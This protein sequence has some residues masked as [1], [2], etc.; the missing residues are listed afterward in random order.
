M[1]PPASAVQP[2]RR[3]LLR[4]VKQEH[5]LP[6]P[7]L[8]LHAGRRPRPAQPL[9]DEHELVAIVAAARR[10]DADGWKRLVGRFDGGLRVIARSY[11]LAPADVDDVVQATWLE[12]VTAIGRLREPA[13][14]GGW[15][16]TVTRR[17]ALRTRQLPMRELLTDDPCR[18]D[19]D[20]SAG[21]E[22][23][24]LEAERQA[25]LAGAIAALPDRHGRLMTVLLT[26]PELDYRQVGEQLSMPVGSIGPS[27]ARALAALARNARL[28]DFSPA[29]AAA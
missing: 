2:L 20:P 22:S 1:Q 25:V 9:E 16:A 10:G 26:Q 6:S 27:R 28:R 13:A 15:L 18:D 4:V 5:S 12:L 7:Q 14:V 24:V 3:T 8:Y 11:R 29:A 23:S 17:N 19:R 21:P